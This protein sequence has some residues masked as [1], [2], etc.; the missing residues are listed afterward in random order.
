MSET[1]DYTEFTG[2]PEAKPET[3]HIIST[4]CT[5]AEM[6]WFLQ[7]ASSARIRNKNSRVQNSEL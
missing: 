6:R 5:Q 2:H 7:T 4:E 3:G 1:V